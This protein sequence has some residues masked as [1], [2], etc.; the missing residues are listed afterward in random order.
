[1]RC[2]VCSSLTQ[3]IFNNRSKEMIMC[4]YPSNILE[5]FKNVEWSKKDFSW[6]FR[7]FQFVLWLR[8]SKQRERDRMLEASLK[9]I[10]KLELLICVSNN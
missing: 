6:L 5:N 9:G 8:M 2:D 1:M 7:F 3:K 4:N 10:S